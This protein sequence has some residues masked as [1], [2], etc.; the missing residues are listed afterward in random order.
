MR[1][2]GDKLLPAEPATDEEKEDALHEA[3]SNIAL[4]Y[5]LLCRGANLSAGIMRPF[6]MMVATVASTLRLSRD[7]FDAEGLY[8][9]HP[10]MY[11]KQI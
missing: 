4:L 1:P 7:R 2:E 6:Y 8:P 9:W 10:W 11:S 5:K 3:R